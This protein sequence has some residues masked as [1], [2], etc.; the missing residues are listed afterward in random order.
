M[1]QVQKD[2]KIAE[3]RDMLSE[4]EN[5][6]QMLSQTLEVS[7]RTIHRWMDVIQSEGYEIW[8]T[9]QN[10]DIRFIILD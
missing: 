7:Q 6:L 8:R 4:G 9:R 3:L 1:P 5:S 2:E 10:E